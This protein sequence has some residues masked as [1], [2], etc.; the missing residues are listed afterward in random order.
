M[1]VENAP[2]VGGW[3]GSCTC[4]DGSVFQVGDLNDYCGSL[5]CV[6]GQAGTCN[7][8]EGAWSSRSVTC[9]T[10]INMEIDGGRRLQ[11]SSDG[12]TPAPPQIPKI[13]EVKYTAEG[14]ISDY[15]EMKSQIAHMMAQQ[16]NLAP[17][18]VELHLEA[19]SVLLH[20]II[21]AAT[22][23]MAREIKEM[24]HSDMWMDPNTVSANLGLPCEQAAA[25]MRRYE[26]PI[27]SRRCGVP[28]RRPS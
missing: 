3:G 2:G 26:S 16:L 6:N 14:D 23:A 1:V 28:R 10:S 18:M 24:F 8:D 9:D 7:E 21:K 27:G 11:P 22:M 12:P 20:F 17:Y 13:V 15:I 4:P 25:G 19:G 5:A